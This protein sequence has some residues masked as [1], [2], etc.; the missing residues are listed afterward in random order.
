MKILKINLKTLLTWF[1][2][3]PF[4]RGYSFVFIFLSSCDKKQSCKLC[5]SSTVEIYQFIWWH[6]EAVFVLESSDE[7]LTLGI[8]LTSCNRLARFYRILLWNFYLFHI[9]FEFRTSRGPQTRGFDVSI[10]ND[11]GCTKGEKLM[12]C[13]NTKFLHSNIKL[14]D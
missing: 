1:H 3:R 10:K 5:P 6:F 13:K 14:Y 4:F 9:S 7:S 12:H 8:K 2:G 11:R